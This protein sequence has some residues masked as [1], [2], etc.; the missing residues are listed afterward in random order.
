M[1]PV[2][3]NLHDSKGHRAEKLFDSHL[4]IYD[5]RPYNYVSEIK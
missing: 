4:S 1:S 2:T 5:G 3:Q